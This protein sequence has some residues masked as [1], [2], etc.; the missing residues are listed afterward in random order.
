MS[1]T[2]QPELAIEPSEAPGASVNFSDRIR[3]WMLVVISLALTVLVLGRLLGGEADRGLATGAATV[4]GALFSETLVKQ[5]NSVKGVS[6]VTGSYSPTSGVFVAVSG[7][8]LPA[9]NTIRWLSDALVPLAARAPSG[10]SRQYVQVLLR[11]DGA[12]GHAQFVRM[13]SVPVGQMQDPSQYREATGNA[14]A[15]VSATALAH[16]RKTTAAVATTGTAGGSPAA[17]AS[18]SPATTAGVAGVDNFDTKTENW[19]PLA[20]QWRF[21]NGEYQQLDS[22][23]FDFITQ[24]AIQPASRFSVSVKMRSI[25]GDLNA[26]VM[27]FQP[28]KGKRN[29]ATLVDLSNSGTYIRWGHYQTGGAYVFDDGKRLTTPVDATKGVVL[30]ISYADDLI[31]IYIDSRQVAQFS[32]KGSD[33]TPAG[34]TGGIGLAVSS[35]KVAFDD[36]GVS[37]I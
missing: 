32:P 25:E 3:Q 18:I 23:G 10:L 7:T 31:R 12:D 4:E 16:P 34:I 8:D 30:E 9:E 14:A 13:V 22:A 33:L 5:L 28:V 26:G 6:N 1:Q 19:S 21:V 11:S 36:F 20:G 29:G 2:M 27:I 17:G 35:A 37:E 24:Y 15:S